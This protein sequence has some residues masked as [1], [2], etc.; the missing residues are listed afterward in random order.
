[1]NEI[2]DNVVRENKVSIISILPYEIFDSKPNLY[3]GTFTIPAGNSKSPGLLEVSR[4]IFWIPMAFGAPSLPAT[5]SPTEVANSIIND[6]VNALLGVGPD[7]KPGLWVEPKTFESSEKA[8][9]ELSL[10]MLPK[11]EAQRR[12]FLSLVNMADAEYNKHKQAQ[13]ISDLQKMAALELNI[14][15]RP[16]LLSLDQLQINNC[17][18][19]YQPVNVN[20]AICGAC[21]YIIDETRYKSMKFAVEMAS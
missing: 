17:P 19:C 3:P 20:A 14:K 15:D 6:Y 13:S 10:K 11:I 9:Q 1:M 4:S 21:R 18:A 5:S 8:R 16:W 2:N 12:W 7:C